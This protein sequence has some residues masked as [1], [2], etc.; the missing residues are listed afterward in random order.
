MQYVYVLNKHGES[1]MPC[2]SGKARILLKQQNACVV[3]RTPFT[4]NS[5][6]V[7]QDTN[8]LSLLALTLAAST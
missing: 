1:L 7:V 4:S 5:C 2:S 8:N 6:T 3:K